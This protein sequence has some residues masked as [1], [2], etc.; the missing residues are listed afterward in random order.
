MTGQVKR[1]T[2]NDG[3]V[4]LPPVSA[5][6]SSETL[7]SSPAETFLRVDDGSPSLRQMPE[8]E[9]F[10]ERIDDDAVYSTCHWLPLKVTL[11]GGQP[12]GFTLSGGAEVRQPLT[13]IKVSD[14][15]LTLSTL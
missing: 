2:V 9:A 15:K 5:L 12:W 1:V 10:D 4:S 14:V 8:I 7:D 11:K 3:E 6:I 13:I